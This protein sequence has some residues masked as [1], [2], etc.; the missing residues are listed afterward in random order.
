MI[1]ASCNM[2]ALAGVFRVMCVFRERRRPF[3]SPQTSAR[4][5]GHPEYRQSGTGCVVINAM[6]PRRHCLKAPTT[7]TTALVP[8]SFPPFPPPPSLLPRH[9]PSPPAHLLPPFPP[10][11]ILVCRRSWRHNKRGN[12]PEREATRSLPPP[13]PPS[14]PRDGWFRGFSDQ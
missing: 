9:P 5:R 2:I 10:W 4:Q 14:P 7:T 6:L 11:W 8:T 12:G 1:R 3:I 13:P